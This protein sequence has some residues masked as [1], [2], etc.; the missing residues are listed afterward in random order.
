MVKKVMCDIDNKI[1]FRQIEKK[2]KVL[3]RSHPDE[4]FILVKGLQNEKHTVAVTG[5]STEDAPVLVEANVG[6]AMDITGTDISKKVCDIQ[7]LDDSFCSIVTTVKYGRKIIDNIRKFLQFQMTVSIVAMFIVF[8]GPC[9]FSE[10][11]LTST[12][13]LWINFILNTFAALA[14]ATEPPNL[15]VFDRSPTHQNDLIFNSTMWRNV[16]GQSIFQVIVLFVL[17]F[18]G[19]D[20]F[21]LPYLQSDPFYP[22][23]EEME[24]MADR[25]TDLGWKLQEPTQKAQMYSIFFQTFVLMQIFNQINSRKLGQKEYNVFASFFNNPIFLV[26]LILT[27]GIQIFIVQYGGHYMGTV[28]LT[29]KQNGYCFAIGAFSLVWGFILKLVPSK[30]FACIR[31]QP[32]Q[33]LTPKEE[34]A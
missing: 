16:I 24:S 18:K 4:K 5:K 23:K 15:N 28:P 9:I 17:L 2:L 19:G 21:D 31:L 33:K 3:A 11:L 1:K 8:A 14:L 30:W 34:Q 32:K 20:L 25:A 12:Q 22:S 7:L 29:W 26:L 13:I 10:S 6:F 27:F